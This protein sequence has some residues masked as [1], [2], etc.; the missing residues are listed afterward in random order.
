MRHHLF[1]TNRFR[2]FF[3]PRLTRLESRDVPTVFTVTNTNDNGAGSLRQAVLDA[4][5]T[6]YPDADSIS[7]DA[8]LVSSGDATISLTTFDT[9][10]DSL[11]AG[12]SAFIVTSPITITG[13]SG[14]N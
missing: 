4:N 10:L 6:A 2:S 7:F 13:P 11:G 3:R 14:E 8:G 1:R 9:G 12:P 5:S